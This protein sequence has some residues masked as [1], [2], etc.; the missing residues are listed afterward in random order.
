MGIHDESIKLNW[1]YLF[2]C[3][4]CVFGNFPADLLKWP[5][6]RLTTDCWANHNEDLA[7]HL[8]ELALKPDFLLKG[9]C[10]VLFV[11]FSVFY[12]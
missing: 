8:S 9:D 4:V 2:I 1:F 10:Q 3:C 7:I 11:C 12:V 5:N 6:L